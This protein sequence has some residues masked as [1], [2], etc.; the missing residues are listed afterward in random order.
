MF[1][2]LCCLQECRYTWNKHTEILL[3]K[4]IQ[5]LLKNSYVRFCGELEDCACENDVKF[6]VELED[7]TCENDHFTREMLCGIRRLHI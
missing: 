6:Y 3:S 2:C 5:I 1:C 4:E 7:Y